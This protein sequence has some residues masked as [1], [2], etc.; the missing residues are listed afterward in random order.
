[1]GGLVGCGDP[2][3]MRLEE[4]YEVIG[5]ERRTATIAEQWLRPRGGTL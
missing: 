2:G 3:A 5:I 4:P 1:M